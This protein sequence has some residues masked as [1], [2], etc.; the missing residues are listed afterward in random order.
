MVIPSG[1]MNFPVLSGLLLT[2]YLCH[3]LFITPESLGIVMEYAAGGELFDRIVKAG[4]FG[5]DEARFFFKQLIRG[6]EFCHNSVREKR[7]GSACIYLCVQRS[8]VM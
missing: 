4:R 2:V 7:G 8:D 3:Q 5:E 6:L 1:H